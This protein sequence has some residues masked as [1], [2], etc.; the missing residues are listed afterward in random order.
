MSDEMKPC[1]FCGTE[2]EEASPS[3]GKVW[4]HPGSKMLPSGCL[5][6]GERFHESAIGMWNRRP[7]PEQSRGDKGHETEQVTWSWEPLTAAGQLSEGDEIRFTIGKRRYTEK[8]KCVLDAGTEAEEV[9][10]NMRKNFYFITSM[11]VGGSS[12]HKNVQVKRAAM[13]LSALGRE[14]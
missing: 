14:E 4:R 2:L 5:L 7:T 10:Y 9:I 13:D 11:A 3:G 1:P 12:S 6:R 8:V